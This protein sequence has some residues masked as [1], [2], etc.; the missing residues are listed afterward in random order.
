M[1]LALLVAA[2]AAPARSAPPAQKPPALPLLSDPALSEAL[3]EFQPL[4]GAWVEYAVIPRKGAQARLRLTVLAPLLRGGRYWLESASQSQG[5]PPVAVRMLLHGPPGRVE[6]LERLY[7]YVGG[8]APMEFP[9][10][11]DLRGAPPAVPRRPG[12]R[13]R[14]R[15]VQEIQV[16]AGRFRAQLIQAGPARV[17]RSEGVPLWGLVKE[18]DARR[19]VELIAFGHSGGRTVFPAEFD[20]G[21]GN[22]SRK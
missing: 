15:G 7:L 2:S 12:P 3:G 5:A 4:P 1:L 22:E 9:V 21:N 20:Q 16:A 8:Q 18:V 10:D 6:N 14:R 17:W 19:R 13:V 11:A